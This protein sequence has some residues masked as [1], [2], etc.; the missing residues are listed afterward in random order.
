MADII[1]RVEGAE[2]VRRYLARAADQMPFVQSLSLNRMANE[3]QLAIQDGL[4]SRFTL[5][6]PEF[7]R[8]TIYRR[9][10]AWP[11]GDN[12]TKQELTAAVRIH[13]DRNLLAKFEEGGVKTAAGGML[14]LP[15]LRLGAPGMIITRSSPYHLRSLPQDLFGGKASTIADIKFVSKNRKSAKAYTSLIKRREKSGKRVFGTIKNGV[16]MILERVGEKLRVLWTFRK[17]VTIEQRLGFFDT[18]QKRLDL[19]WDRTLLAAMDKALET[20]T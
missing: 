14:A 4:P 11:Q 2:D 16:P 20:R 7:I 9:P 15:T 17:Q 18:A 10:G 1:A 12:S 13:P 5:R 8:R 3:I 19:G 6:R